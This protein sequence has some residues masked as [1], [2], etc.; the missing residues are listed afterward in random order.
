MDTQ[1][2]YLC[3]ITYLELKRIANIRKFIVIET[4]K[5]LV[6]SFILSRLDYCNSLLAGISKD[7]LNR[8]QRVQNS[9]ARLILKVPRSE[10]ITPLLKQLHWLPVHLRIK[11][12]IA[13]FCFKSIN[14]LCPLYIKDLLK[15]YVPNRALRSCSA[16]SL[17]EPQSRL[18]TYRDRSFSSHAPRVWN[19]LPKHVKEAKTI[20]SFKS[21]LKT[22]LFKMYFD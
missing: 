2:N 21:Q 10:H 6:S 7:K 16:D 15:Y 11:Y 8:L 3:K 12:K 5:T 1:I 19:A 18:K 13:M 20:S 4:S 22:H 9:A 17:V 14:G